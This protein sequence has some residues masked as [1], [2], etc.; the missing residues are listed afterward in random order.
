MKPEKCT[1]PNC[2]VCEYS[3]CQWEDAEK[4]IKA[5][6]KR[7]RYHADIE[8]SRRKQR[9]YR[10]RKSTYRDADGLNKNQRNM[11][12]FI[13]SYTRK[14]L[15]SPSIG[16]IGESVGISI[17]TVQ[18]NLIRIQNCGLIRLGKGQR[19]IQLLGYELVQKGVN[20]GKTTVD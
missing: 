16:E 2:F 1:Y 18:S 8:E 5:E 3:D 4:D 15:Y 12:D 14:N 19:S 17:S 11:Y 13:V 10:K 7:K 20:H 6:K 9:E